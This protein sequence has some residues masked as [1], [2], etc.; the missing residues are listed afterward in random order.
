[1]TGID[2]A[3]IVDGVILFSSNPEL[4][5]QSA[6]A[7]DR[8]YGAV[9]VERVAGSSIFAAAA[10]TG[11]AMNYAQRLT[12]TVFVIALSIMLVT[13]ELM[14]KLLSAKMV[15]PLLES[16]DNLHMGLLKTQ[17]DAHFVVNT[18]TCIEGL[19]HQGKTEKI[20]T[21]AQNLAY[22]LKARHTPDTEINVFEQMEDAERYIEIMNIRSDD[23]FQVVMD[24]HDELF[25]CRMLVQVLQPIVENALTHGL[26]NK[27]SDCRLNISGR[28]ENGGLLFEVSDNGVGMKP[29]ELRAL[30]DALDIAGGQDDVEYRLKGIG[31]TNIQRRIRTRYGKRYGLTVGGGSEEGLTVTIRLP[32]VRE[33]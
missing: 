22:M 13:S 4:D 32:V 12:A 19:A 17:I 16:T 6:E 3:V 30:Q 26:G 18:V 1:M 15:N 2:I 7:L 23:K 5:G 24:V 33:K 28:L 8:L 29:E 9:A 20:A 27:K 10:L 25:R 14:Y 31:L 11:E 21:A